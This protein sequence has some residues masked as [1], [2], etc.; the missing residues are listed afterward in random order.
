MD[1]F[2]IE[3]EVRDKPHVAAPLRGGTSTHRGEGADETSHPTPTNDGVADGGKP[4]NEGQGVRLASCTRNRCCHTCIHADGSVCD[5][6]GEVAC[7]DYAL[8]CKDYMEEVPCCWAPELDWIISLCPDKWLVRL[9]DV[10]GYR[11]R[12][13]EY[14]RNPKCRISGATMVYIMMRIDGEM[15][16]RR[17][18]NVQ[19]S[20]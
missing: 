3:S 15:K 12:G 8:T 18:N 4:D 17:E 6:A 2:E 10:V 19:I 13:E 1:E 7:S 11:E 14:F 5:I 20:Y 16:W 9:R